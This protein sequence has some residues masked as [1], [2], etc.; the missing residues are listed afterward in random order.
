MMHRVWEKIFV[1]GLIIL[2]ENAFASESNGCGDD[3]YKANDN[4]VQ[5]SQPTVLDDIGSRWQLSLACANTI[6]PDINQT[7]LA[8]AVVTLPVSDLL[9]YHPFNPRAPPVPAS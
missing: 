3:R 1:A 6:Q 9:K 2:G 7:Y 4:A 8:F 5:L